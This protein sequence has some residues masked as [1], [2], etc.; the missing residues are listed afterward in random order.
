MKFFKANVLGSNPERTYLNERLGSASWLGWNG[1]V[2]IETK[3]RQTKALKN[4]PLDDFLA[5]GKPA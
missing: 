1:D 5:R 4:S 3:Q 2:R